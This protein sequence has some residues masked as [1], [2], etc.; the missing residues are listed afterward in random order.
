MSG[1]VA[2]LTGPP[3]AGKTTVARIIAEGS[4]GPAVHLHADDFWHFIRSGWIAPY[5][6]QS[7]AQ[8]TTVIEVVGQAAWGYAMGGYLVVVDGIIG[9]WFL[10]PF[11]THTQDMG[12]LLR[13]VV[14]RPNLMTALQRAQARSDQALGDT[15][16]IRSL[17]A[18]FCDLGLLEQHVIDT[19][20][21]DLAF[22]VE[23]VRRALA[24]D[25]F[26]LKATPL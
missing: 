15:G 5:L 16:P 22:T 25:R 10:G 21:Q 4:K 12:L 14:L 20:D 6:P 19:S 13:Y 17:H 18:Q 1:E 2:I 3:G 7:H 8:K 24:D 11:R 26:A 9:P 23:A